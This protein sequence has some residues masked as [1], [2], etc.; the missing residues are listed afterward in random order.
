M[1]FNPVALVSLNE[2]E[3]WRKAR[4]QGKSES[5]SHSVASES[6]V[7]PW[8]VSCQVPLSMEFSRQ[9]YWRGYTF[10][11]S[12]HLPNHGIIPTSLHC[13]QILYHLSNQTRRENAM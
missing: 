12:G 8:T 9:E 10:P 13:R 2:E 7:I 6:F 4:I 11:S 1:G 3:I 5:V